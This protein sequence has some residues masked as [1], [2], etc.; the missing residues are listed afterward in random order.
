[1]VDSGQMNGATNILTWE[2]SNCGFGRSFRIEDRL[3][4]NAKRA[5]AGDM[6]Q[7]PVSSG[8]S[9]VTNTAAKS[10]IVHRSQGQLALSKFAKTRNWP[11]GEG[12]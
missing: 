3:R 8:H 12:G 4:I 11:D 5:C 1:M 10:R 7:V 2:T 6:K 9:V